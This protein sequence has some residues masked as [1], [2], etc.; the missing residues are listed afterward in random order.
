MNNEFWK[1]ALIIDLNYLLGLRASISKDQQTF[2]LEHDELDS[3]LNWITWDQPLS[4]LDINLS[5]DPDN[6][7]L[8]S[9]SSSFL[10]PVVLPDQQSNSLVD[11]FFQSLKDNLIRLR[12]NPTVPLHESWANISLPSLFGSRAHSHK[13][14]SAESQCTPPSLSK[15]TTLYFNSSDCSRRPTFS[16]ATK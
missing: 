14:P 6:I 11:G 1:A 5:T 2:L 16:L 8:L 10:S 13:S 12:D 4:P 3:L 15:T 7:T 9:S